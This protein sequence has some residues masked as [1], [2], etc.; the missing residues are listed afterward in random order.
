MLPFKTLIIVDKDAQ[1]AVYLQIANRIISLIQEGILQ[2]GTYLPGS[3]IL[4]DLLQLHRKTVVAAY[5]E[6]VSQDWI[7]AIPRKGMMVATN[8]PEIKPRSFQQPQEAYQEE[9]G[10]SYNNISTQFQVKTKPG[11]KRLIINDGFPDIRLAPMDEWIKECRSIIR[12]PYNRRILVTSPAFGNLH[13]RNEMVNYLAGTRGLNI[14]AD[15]VMVTRGAQMSIYL[16]AAMIIKQ[17]DN[18]IVGNPNYFFANLTFQQLGANLLQVPVD[19]NGLD[20]GAVEKLC[21]TKKIRMLYIISHHHHPTTVTLSA[22]RRM[23]LLEII[24][25]Y[26]LAV[27]EDDYD[28]DFHYSSSPILPLASADHGGNVIYVGSFTKSLG[29]SIR[30]GF[31]IAPSKFIDKTA[32]LRRLMDLGGDNLIEEALANM[33]SNGTINRHIKKA[34]KSYW[35]RRDLAG[36]LLEK[37]LDKYAQFKLPLGGMAI[38][39][40]FNKKYPLTKVAVKAQEYGLYMANGERYSY[41]STPINA[42]RFGFASL[43]EKELHTA[44]DILAKVLKDRL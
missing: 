38:W 29:L 26:N 44:T 32:A 40:Q 39:L 10:F 20:I 8:L 16:A 42:M 15:N 2:P 5:D 13:L 33:L 21:A 35:E 12:Q 11:P 31:M 17:G 22:E 18:V 7:M 34:N 19:E 43:N 9:P 41:M 1:Q 4:A 14:K 24:R 37:K 30:I 23:K 27:I 36:E 6:L 28:Y 3:R 25:K